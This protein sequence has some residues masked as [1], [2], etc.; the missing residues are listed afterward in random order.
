MH[1]GTAATRAVLIVTPLL[2]GAHAGADVIDLTPLGS[3]GTVN[4]ALFRQGFFQP[5][6]TGVI[7]SFVR[8]QNSNGNQ[9]V[10][11]GYNTSGRPVAFN[12]ITDGNFTRNLTI[13]ELNTVTVDGTQYFEFLLDANEPN[14]GNRFIS[15][16]QVQIFTSTTGS[17][18]TGNIASLGTPIYNL[19][20]GG[21]SWIRLDS[22]LDTGGSGEGDMTMLVPVSVF[23]GAGANTF[24]YLYSRFGDNIAANSGFEEWAVRGQVIPLPTSVWMGGG[25]LA[26]IGLARAYRRR[27]LAI[28]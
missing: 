8:I 16:D 23:G 20:T 25:C 17:Q 15:L 12:E 11:Q 4:G 7:R 1:Q 19:D 21:D 2:L 9:T 10:E 18:T 13:G 26:A 14:N 5:A 27:Y 3:S 22:S 6:G 28:G 24:V